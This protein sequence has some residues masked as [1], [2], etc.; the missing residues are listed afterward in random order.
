MSS[1][2]AA[3]GRAVRSGR[4]SASRIGAGALRAPVRIPAAGYLLIAAVVVAA[5]RPPQAFAQARLTPPP[6]ATGARHDSVWADAVARHAEDLLAVGYSF[7]A[8]EWALYLAGDGASA[9]RGVALIAKL[10][11]HNLT[12]TEFL[13]LGS[14]ATRGGP[15]TWPALLALAQRASA[16]RNATASTLVAAAR[17]LGADAESA[18]RVGLGV[19]RPRALR[20]FTIGV[21]APIDGRLARQGEAFV[22]AAALAV[23][24]HNRSAR[25]PVTLMAG[26]T[27]GEPLAAARAAAELARAGVGIVVGDFLAATTVPAAAAA[28]AAGIPLVTPAPGR[29][30]LAAIG[31][32]VFR[33]IAPRAYQAEALARAARDLGLSRLAILAPDSE[34]GRDLGERFARAAAAQGT[35][36]VGREMYRG[37][38]VD[39]GPALERLKVAAPEGIFLPGTPRELMTAIPQLAYYE[40]GARLFA[41]E[42]LAGKDVSAVALEYLDEA[43]F[44]ENYYEPPALGGETFAARYRRRFGGEA[45][46][47]AARGYIATS[48]AARAL[49]TE[50]TAPE[51]LAP[52]L[53]ASAIQRTQLLAPPEG[54]G[55]VPVLRLSR[56]GITPIPAGGF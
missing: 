4:R 15:G 45:D 19:P 38:E 49:A 28:A 53:A 41:L 25:Y 22:Q 14:A 33:T 16:D 21:L 43:Y 46:P 27:R 35:A 2:A 18:A 11:P 10:P 32:H 56:S 34:G 40:V 6:A 42:E 3:R 8:A 24:E 37:G 39:F 47:I 23:E 29:E 12:A 54:G 13:Y 51:D 1:P 44:A 5:A 17:A 26:D 50:L 48:L 36:I 7:R 9:R 31:P 20:Q 55:A 30:D 52:A